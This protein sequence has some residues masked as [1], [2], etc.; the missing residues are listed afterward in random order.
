MAPGNISG[1]PL[2]NKARSYE[3]WKK[4]IELWCEIT[5]IKVEKRGITIALAL[6]DEECQFGK[7]IKS[8]VLD[9]VTSAMLKAVEGPVH[10]ID[11]LDKILGKDQTVDRF[12]R[13]KEFIICKRTDNQ[14]IDSFLRNFDSNVNRLKAVGQKIDGDIITFMLLLNANLQRWEISLIMSKL[15][16]DEVTLVYEKAKK[17]MRQVLGSHVNSAD[18]SVDSSEFKNKLVIKSEPTDEVLATN[19]FRGGYK[20]GQGPYRGRG[21]GRGTGYQGR[22]PNQNGWKPFQSGDKHSDKKNPIGSDGTQLKCRVCESVMHFVKDCPHKSEVVNITEDSQESQPDYVWFTDIALKVDDD[23]QTMAQFTAE[24]INCAALDTCCT[25]SVAGKEWM[26]I[27]IASLPDKMKSKVIGPMNGFKVF[28][29][30]NLGKLKSCGRYL[31]PA[32]IAGKLDQLDVDV[33]ESDIPLLLSKKDM[34]KRGMMLNLCEDKVQYGNNRSEN[35]F[36]SSAGH[37]LLPLFEKSQMVCNV[38]EVLTVDLNACNEKDCKKALI[39]LHKQFGHRPKKCFVNLL[40]G[41]KVWEPRMDKI[42]DGIIDGCEAC[43]LR[44]RSPDRPAVAMP[45]ASDFNEKV[46]IDLKKWKSGHILYMIDM[47]SRLTQAAFIPNKV[48]DQVV[49]AILVKWVANYGVPKAILN[50]NGGEFANSEVQEMKS[51]LNIKDLTTGAE[52]PF[53]NG[54]CEKNHQTVDN[55]LERIE[56]DYPKLPM[57]AKLAWA[58]MAKNCLLNVYGYSP[59]QLVFGRNPNLPNILTD[60][61]PSWEDKTVGERLGAHLTALKNSRK[62]FIESESSERIKRALRAKIRCADIEVSYGDIVYYIR[63]RENKWCGPATVMFQ[64]GKVIFLRHGASIVRVSA[65]KLVKAGEELASSIMEKENPNSNSVINPVGSNETT[66]NHLDIPSETNSFQSMTEN[67]DEN[68]NVQQNILEEHSNVQKNIANANSI[69][70]N[71]DNEDIATVQER[72]R[73]CDDRSNKRKADKELTPVKSTKQARTA[74]KV[75]DRI[76]LRQDDGSWT[77]ATITSR[78]GKVGGIHSNIWNIELEDSSKAWFYSDKVEFEKIQDTPEEVHAVMIPKSQQKQPQCLEAKQIE[79]KKLQDFKTYVEVEDVGQPR[80]STTWVVCEKDEGVKARLVARGYEETNDIVSDSP[81]M[82]KSSLRIILALAASNRWQVETTD[83]KSAF[84]QGV[85][86][87]RDVYV[88]PPREANVEKNKI[89]K[90][91]KCLYGLK[92]ASRQWYGRVIDELFKAGFSVTELDPAVFIYMKDKSVIGIV[93]LHVDDF[94]H[95]GTIEFNETVIKPFM[96]HFQVGKNEKGSFMYTGFKINQGVNGIMLDQDAYVDRNLTVLPLEPSRAKEKH[97][98]LT[99]EEL[100]DLRKMVGGINWV[101][102]ATRPDLSFELIDLSTKFKKGVVDDLVR[103]RKVI[104]HLKESESKIFFPK[105]DISSLELLVYTDASFAN[106]SNGLG[107]VGGQLIFLKDK[108]ENLSLIEWQANKVRR[109]VRSTLAAEA[110]SLVDGLEYAM[111]LRTVIAELTGKS[112]S[113]IKIKA[114]T[115][116]RSCVDAILSTSLIDDKRLRIEMGML[117]TML[118]NREIDQITWVQGSEQLAD[119]LTKR[120]ASGYNLLHVLQ[121]GHL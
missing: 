90:L 86:I 7:D 32:V 23:P 87:D 45:M 96:Q 2:L 37:Y 40:K 33:I 9:N 53:Q 27:Y 97:S 50:D 61:P 57:N 116:N 118:K 89:W 106:V 42:L 85:D 14:D 48:P 16:F 64:D 117:K 52:S 68:L 30:G 4:E 38:E 26:K 111:Y 77:E 59:Y 10:I 49:A 79:L 44:K 91:L 102:R 107:S 35:L 73:H 67:I 63:E 17:Q 47:Y 120:G 112:V 51:W 60:G 94:I 82:T 36:T 119:A 76:K 121:N 98:S 1:V 41:A 20:R 99:D 72:S 105:L 62:G 100:T 71:I 80:I 78:G 113:S 28:Q 66:E 31:I 21:Q 18:A 88:K 93:G 25:S 11:Y 58:T 19:N 22:R 83:I 13:F 92:D 75:N 3:T 5:E 70:E 15:D 115:D 55:I 65:N 24:A 104:Q 101:V 110:L 108:F 39:K 29:F 43:I 74:L 103:A 34:K 46:A 6:P 84:L 109:I 54:L 8:E 12:H 69:N 114:I 56:S 81:T 95:C